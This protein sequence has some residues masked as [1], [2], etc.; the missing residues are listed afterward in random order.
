VK[1]ALLLNLT[2]MSD[3]PPISIIW[4]DSDPNIYHSTGLFRAQNWNVICFNE[5]ADALNA[6]YKK[7]LKLENIKCIIT[8]MMERDGRRERGLLN[9]LQMVDNMKRIW[10][11][12]RT[13]DPPLMVVNSLTA[14]A[15]QCKKYGVDIVV[16]ANRNLV[17]KQVIDRFNTH[18]NRRYGNSKT[19]LL[20]Y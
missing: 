4:V 15:N 20:K 13:T 16:G 1:T 11:Q 14:D 7:Q 2:K 10:M 5:T 12:T 3:Y 8:S 6:L 9:G 17:Q 19:A 18:L